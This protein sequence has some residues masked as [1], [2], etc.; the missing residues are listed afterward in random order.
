MNVCGANI[1]PEV[2][3]II[4]LYNKGDLFR[5]SL[6]SVLAQ[7][8]NGFEVIII[9]DG[10]TDNPKRI[11]DEFEDAR[12]K[13]YYQ[14]N[15][16]LPSIARNAGIKYAKASYIA[17]LDADDVWYP[18]KL[19]RCFD[20]FKKHPEVALVCHDQIMK[21]NSGMSIRYIRYGPNRADMFRSL[22]F[23]GGCFSPSAAMVKKD[24]LLEVGFFREYP[25]LY[26]VEDYDLWL[27]LSKK[28]KFYF[29]S[30]ILGEYTFNEKS[31]TRDYQRHY[32]NQKTMLKVSFREYKEK[33]F[34][35][36][37]LIN[38]R[39]LRVNLIMLKYLLKL[40]NFGR[41][42]AKIE[43]LTDQR[44]SLLWKGIDN[45]RSEADS[46]FV[47]MQEVIPE[48]IVSGKLGLEVGCGHGLDTQVMAS[49][50][51]NTDIVSVD[52]SDGVYTAANLNRN[53]GNVSIVQASALKLPFKNG[54]FDFCY[55][56]G[57][58]HHTAD[59]DQCFAEINRVLRTSGKVFLY[60]YEDHSGNI[61]KIYPL[62]AI[63]VVRKIT[64]RMNNKILYGL[65]L[66][67]SP[68]VFTLF[69]VPA[70]IFRHFKYTKK[71]AESMPFNFG[72][73][74][75]SLAG[76]LYDRFG[77]PVELRF[78]Q[79]SLSKLLEKSGFSDIQFSKLKASA[80]LVV[81]ASKP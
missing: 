63:G 3:V 44:Y 26:S 1:I 69:S 68:V 62:K 52:I 75:F 49:H 13:Y 11:V 70:I 27:R 76:D 56:F 37:L 24:A 10:S 57:V 71:L 54:I 30:E 72:R 33:R 66:L 53:F 81:W 42:T 20:V 16:G 59:P 50:N 38:I 21:D 65:C 7:T 17:F 35:D 80:G 43:D 77:A 67:I 51:A 4:T 22:L 61:L 8:F 36:L 18:D 15:R 14:E 78:N 9:D 47:K 31:I 55:S 60:L 74:P 5:K 48:P 2:S 23:R 41:D 25:E 45:R 6:S 32:N 40:E 34:L 46:H 12:I 39:M 28:Y 19:S 64:S 58:I 79:E 73:S 29:I